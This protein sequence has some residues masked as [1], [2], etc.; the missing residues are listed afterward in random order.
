MQVIWKL[1]VLQHHWSPLLRDADL[2]CVLPRHLVAPKGETSS[3]PHRIVDLALASYSR[4]FAIL[5]PRA[6][7]VSLHGIPGVLECSGI[8]HAL[9]FLLEDAVPIRL[10]R[11][12][13]HRRSRNPTKHVLQT[14]VLVSSIHGSAHN[15][16]DFGH[17]VRLQV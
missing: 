11:H 10:V 12:R 8:F 4:D 17:D 16:H 15:I 6:E 13:L 9:V 1:R 2:Q 3:H 14:A 5:L 7:P